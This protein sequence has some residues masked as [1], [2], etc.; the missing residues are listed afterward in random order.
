M[1]NTRPLCRT[2]LLKPSCGEFTFMGR[3][4]APHEA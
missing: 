3:P 4:P 2:L 1:W